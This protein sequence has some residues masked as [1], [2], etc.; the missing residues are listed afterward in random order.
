MASLAGDSRPIIPVMASTNN[1]GLNFKG[2]S[3]SI[4]PR[5]FRASAFTQPK[6]GGMGPNGIMRA[7]APHLAACY[8][9]ATAGERYQ[10]TLATQD[11]MVNTIGGLASSHSGPARDMV[12]LHD[13]P[14]KMEPADD[15]PLTYGNNAIPLAIG[16]MDTAAT[17]SSATSIRDPDVMGI[18]DCKASAFYPWCPPGFKPDNGSP[19][20]SRQAQELQDGSNQEEQEAKP[21]LNLFK[22]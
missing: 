7:P 20:S 9:P 19:S 1:Y 4:A 5:A 18:R 15:N 17:A 2:S 10:S 11:A 13:L 8:M 21:L 22:P 14:I 12:A 3:T 16:V 6:R